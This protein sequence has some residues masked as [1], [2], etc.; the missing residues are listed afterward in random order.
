M[1]QDPYKILA[2]EF[3]GWA[4]NG[5]GESMENGHSDVTK[6]LLDQVAF[7][8]GSEVLDVG[9]GNGWLVREM[10]ARG[11]SFGMGVDISAEMITVARAG[12]NSIDYS[13]SSKQEL[14][15][16][17]NGE[18]IARPDKSFD[19]ITNVESLY[20][21]PDP[22]QALIEWF[23]LAKDNGYLT[24]MMDLYKESIATHNWI[25]ALDVPVHLFSKADLKEMLSTSGWTL[26]SMSQ[27]TDRRP[28]KSFESFEASTYWPSYEQYKRYR[29]TGSL[30][31][32]AQKIV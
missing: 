6:Q 4:Q 16:V 1:K 29:E 5:R 25:E 12:S 22:Q 8:S 30:C 11:A 18:K 7:P 24:I 27:I 19:V 3:D 21:Y 14:Y 13:N 20:Y 17:S 15:L 10:I 2:N 32:I 23:R 9:C 26:I 31:I 28:M